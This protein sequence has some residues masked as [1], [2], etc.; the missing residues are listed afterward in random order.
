MILFFS[1][2]VNLITHGLSVRTSWQNLGDAIVDR[3]YLELYAQGTTVMNAQQQ[4]CVGYGRYVSRLYSLSLQM[5]Y[6][7]LR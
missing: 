7:G 2:K 1:L 3:G 6:L 4:T 5:C